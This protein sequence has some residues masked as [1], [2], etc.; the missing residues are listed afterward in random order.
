[1]FP[2]RNTCEEVSEHSL[3]S[4]L[5]KPIAQ[6]LIDH[7]PHVRILAAMTAVERLVVIDFHSALTLA[8]P[9]ATYEIMHVSNI[10]YWSLYFSKS[11]K[12]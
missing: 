9:K 8:S 5:K 7:W 2:S 10:G 1:M 4:C 3:I 12:S 6:N 11:F